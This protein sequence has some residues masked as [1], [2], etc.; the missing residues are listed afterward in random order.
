MISES[1]IEGN[2]AHAAEYAIDAG[3]SEVADL[4]RWAARNLKTRIDAKVRKGSGESFTLTQMRAALAQIQD[5]TLALVPKLR[6]VTVDVGSEAALASATRAVRYLEHA[7]A[8]FRGV[9]TTPLAIREASVLDAAVE[10]ARSSILHRLAS[11]GE[12]VENA[13]AEPHPA[14]YGV[15]ERYGIETIDHFE[16]ELRR[17]LIAQKSWAQME[18][19]IVTR[20]PF[21]QGAPAHWAK[22]IVRTEVMGAYGR[23]SWEAIREVDERAGDMCKFIS[24]TFDERTGAD[25]FDIH[26]QCR[27]PEETF[28]SWFGHFQHSPNRPNDRGVVVPHRISWPVPPTLAPKSTAEVAARW[29]RDGNRKA[30]PPRSL[31][32]TVPFARF[33]RSSPHAIP[34]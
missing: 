26:G 5:V 25:S 33:G 21:L 8:L 1:L 10:G 11:S 29:R 20:S 28:Q 24:E 23:S 30:M 4:L 18:D 19:A 7:D 14:K 22:R 13:D 34:A 16:V 32:T 31:I 6:D 27:R 3:G 17:G 12:P 2:R 9:G 15:L